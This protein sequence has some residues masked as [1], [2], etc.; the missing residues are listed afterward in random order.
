MNYQR[1]A[2]IWV[3]GWTLMQKCWSKNQNT[4]KN[5]F[6]FMCTHICLCIS[7]HFLYQSICS[8]QSVYF[9]LLLLDIYWELKPWEKLCDQ[10][11]SIFRV[12]GKRLGPSSS[13]TNFTFQTL[14]FQTHLKEEVQTQT[15]QNLFFT[16]VFIYPVPFEKFMRQH[17]LWNSSLLHKE[18]CR[19]KIFSF[20]S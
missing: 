6:V 16:S 13:P 15:Q 12:R 14:Q 7:V 2:V 20:S 1:R 4:H 17:I 3:I 18:R 5:S 8:G 11:C 10:K 9:F 19:K